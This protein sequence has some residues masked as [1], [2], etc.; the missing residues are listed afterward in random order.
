[1]EQDIN[2][3]RRAQR[4][5]RSAG[6]LL[7]QQNF[8]AASG[9]VDAALAID[10]A[11]LPAQALK[12]RIVS[13]RA[14]AIAARQAAP[15]AAAVPTD[16]PSKTMA[17]RFVPSGVDAQ[18]W[19]GF[20]A[21]IQERRYRALLESIKTAVAV[22]D[23]LAARAALEEA[24]ELRPESADLASL[25]SRVALLPVSI[26]VADVSATLW[27]RAFSAVTLLLVG[28]ALL[29][30]IDW[31]R[32]GVGPAAD[33]PAASPAISV[34]A[35]QPADTTSQPVAGT[36][37]LRVAIPAVSGTPA[38]AV[39][40]VPD[41]STPVVPIAREDA[42]P[43]GTVGVKR[44]EVEESGSAA[45]TRPSFRPASI[46]E[47]AVP[48][49]G[50]IPDDYVAAPPRRTDD[51]VVASAPSTP[52]VAPAP[53]P[54]AS[55]VRQPTSVVTPPAPTPAALS[56]AAAAPSAVVVASRADETRVA[57]VLDRYARA[58]GDLNATAAHAVWPGVDER[59]LARAFSSLASQTVS[60]DNCD[61][62]VS[63]AKANA[64]C[65]GRASYVAK[66]GSREPRSE[67]RT[68]N[69]ELRRDGDAW[70]IQNAEAR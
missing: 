41:T 26:P 32:P 58:Y 18:S 28:I 51:V 43:V 24:R 31:W 2:P 9:E 55:A 15:G 23:G 49:R 7:A 59:A 62:S 6:A 56:P 20:E 64:S 38:A 52:V 22:G 14:Q 34:P 37:D 16:A 33:A 10:P 53:A 45:A 12:Q 48:A 11:S 47:P 54:F 35:A 44:V 70:M 1:M 17:E 46:S 39:A 69:F 25:E 60:F 40:A 19:I 8:D 27:S 4:H 50:E 65:H 61:I 5:L 13:A 66:I 57:Q 30:G 3:A 68:W 36:P 21:R 42:Q 29:V 67:A 63:G